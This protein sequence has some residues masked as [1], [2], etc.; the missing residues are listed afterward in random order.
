MNLMAADVMQNTIF[1]VVKFVIVLPTL[2]G[3]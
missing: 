2:Q 1:G 3:H